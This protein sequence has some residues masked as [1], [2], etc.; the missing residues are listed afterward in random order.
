MIREFDIK[1]KSYNLITNY[2]ENSFKYYLA[3]AFGT[4]AGIIA[5]L[6]TDYHNVNDYNKLLFISVP[7]CVLFL[8]SMIITTLCNYRNAWL[9]AVCI[10]TCMYILIALEPLFFLLMLAVI[11]CCVMIS[12][13]ILSVLLIFAGV[14]TMIDRFSCK[15]NESNVNNDNEHDDYVEYD[16][17][18]SMMLFQ[19]EN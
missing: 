8:L 15:H 13:I 12:L 3:F 1:N 18:L 19:K 17:D 2:N 14:K 16:T 5:M 6:M 7:V 11:I 10:G 4:A 9:N